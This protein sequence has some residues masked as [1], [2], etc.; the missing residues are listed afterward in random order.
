M[1]IYEYLCPDCK[2]KF[3]LVRPFSQATEAVRCPQCHSEAKRLLST[4]AH[5]IKDMNELPSSW[6]KT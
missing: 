6:R 2:H 4:F 5:H 1:P 3:E